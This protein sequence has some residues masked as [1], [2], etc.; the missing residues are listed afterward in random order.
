MKIVTVEYR[1]LRTTHGYNNKTVGAVAEVEPGQTPEGALAELQ[2]WVG[3]QFGD[4]QERYRLQERVRDL[5]WQAENAEQ[6]V[7]LVNRKWE[8]YVAFLE[9][10]GI[11][12]PDSI[13]ESL[14]EIPF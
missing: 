9:K 3:R 6:K 11:E 4:E 5:E 2:E 7:K 10:L 13:P 1:E 14:E 8:A 12:R